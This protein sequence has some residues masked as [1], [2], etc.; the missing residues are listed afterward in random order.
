MYQ[1]AFGSIDRAPPAS[2]AGFARSNENAGRPTSAET[3]GR[4][5][6]SFG[7]WPLGVKAIA[8]AMRENIGLSLAVEIDWRWLS[9]R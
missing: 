1:A 5:G 4:I 9:W 2:I 7:P 3:M 8:A 6:A